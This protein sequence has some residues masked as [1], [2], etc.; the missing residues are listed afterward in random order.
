LVLFLDE[1]YT[2]VGQKYYGRHATLLF[3]LELARH[4]QEATLFL[5]V[6]DAAA[7][8]PDEPLVADLSQAAL[9]VVALPPYGSLAASLRKLPQILRIFRAHRPEIAGARALFIRVPSLAG[10]AL[11]ELGRGW[12]CKPWYHV[13]AN[14]ETQATPVSRGGAGEAL[15][16]QLARLLN[17]LTQWAARGLLMSAVGEELAECFRRGAPFLPRPRA[18]RNI[19]EAVQ[20]EGQ[21]HFRP[22]TCQ[23]QAVRLLRV[24]QLSPSKGLEVLLPAVRLLVD[25]GVPVRLDV[26]GGAP[27]AYLRELQ[28]LSDSLGLAPAV[29]WLGPLDYDALQRQYRQA[30]IQVISSYGEGLP[31]VILEGWGACLPLVSTAVGGIPAL[32]KDGES[33]LLAPPGDPPAL[34]RAI[35]RMIEDGA[36]RRKIIAAGFVQAREFSRERQAARLAELLKSAG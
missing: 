2:R 25:A 27:P 12:G 13:C 6:R 29:A 33:G 18:V 1:L 4:F 10:L 23:G 21:F 16:R 20:S 31:R 7:P 30:D 26:V 36:L 15:W 9:R 5:T 24:C 3:L 22:D 11:G 35:V 34:A 17:L 28:R 8:D 32:V 14:I 19:L